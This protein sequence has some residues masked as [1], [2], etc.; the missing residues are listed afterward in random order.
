MKKYRCNVFSILGEVV[1]FCFISAESDAEAIAAGQVF[2]KQVDARGGVE[3]LLGTIKVFSNA[4]PLIN[5]RRGRRLYKPYLL[6]F[7]MDKRK[8]GTDGT[9][10][11]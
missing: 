2:A 9:S 11:S 6:P 8:L 10:S 4:V 1:D 7:W 3:V 5:I